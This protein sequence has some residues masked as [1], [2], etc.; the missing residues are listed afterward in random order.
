MGAEG[1]GEI[2]VIGKVVREEGA[3]E[4]GRGGG[5]EG[6]YCKVGVGAGVDGEVCDGGGADEGGV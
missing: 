4:G 6:G 1:E 3:A 5:V 2:G